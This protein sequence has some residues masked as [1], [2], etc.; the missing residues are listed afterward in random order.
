[1]Q[2][3]DLPVGR[4][5]ELYVRSLLPDGYH[6]RQTELEERV[7]GLVESGH[8]SDRSVHVWGKQAPATR[9][10]TTTDVG[11]FV[12][13]RVELF[14][15]W[16]A[17]NDR[18]LAPAFEVREVDNRLTDDHYRAIRFPTA[19]LAEF[20]GD[21]LTC[22]T[23]HADEDGVTTITDRLASLEAENHTRFKPVDQ[24]ATE[25]PRT[26]ADSSLLVESD[27]GPDGEPLAPE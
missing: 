13:E 25:E 19:L 18:S 11:Q 21:A 14:R 16:A 9:E 6:Q 17:V 10:A 2:G 5:M 26:D 23:P 1:M 12:L 8:A 7:S 22:V 4:R 15:E 27:E 20:R 24:V 3:S